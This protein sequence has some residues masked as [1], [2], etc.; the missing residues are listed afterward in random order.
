MKLPDNNFITGIFILIITACSTEQDNS[1]Y[2]GDPTAD[3]KVLAQN[4]ESS[5]SDGWEEWLSNYTDSGVS[6]IRGYTD[7]FNLSKQ[8]YN[9]FDKYKS[10][11]FNLG[12]FDIL[13]QEHTKLTLRCHYSWILEPFDHQIGHSSYCD[14]WLVVIKEGEF[15]KIDDWMHIRCEN[16]PIF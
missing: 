5:L 16:N 9:T 2:Q 1:T 10:I 8:G 14:L 15:F 7:A 11:R 4:L 13:E 6:K 3:L 12:S